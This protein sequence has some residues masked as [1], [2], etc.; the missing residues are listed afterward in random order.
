MPSKSKITLKG[1]SKEDTETVL[2]DVHKLLKT[3]Q[4]MDG[5]LLMELAKDGMEIV[6]RMIESGSERKT[7]LLAVLKMI[8][9]ELN[10]SDDLKEFLINEIIDGAISI[11]I[12]Y[13]AAASKGG[14]KINTKKPKWCCL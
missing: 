4:H 11:A 12:D 8:V 2:K 5:A 3:D 6:E 13:I 9:S 7:V 14:L 10:I 1:G